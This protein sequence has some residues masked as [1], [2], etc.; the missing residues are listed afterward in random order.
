MTNPE[1][2]T[3]RPGL[4]RR[5]SALTPIASALMISALA[6][7][8]FQFDTGSD[9]DVRWDNTWGFLSERPPEFTDEARDW[10]FSDTLRGARASA[11]CFSLVET[12]K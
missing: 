8:A 11:T 10:L 4:V 2:F 7:S 1:T 3:K 6:P 12:A 5:G 9:W